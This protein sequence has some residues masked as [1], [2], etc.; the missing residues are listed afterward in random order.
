[1]RRRARPSPPECAVNAR[2]PSRRRRS[3]ALSVLLAGRGTPVTA[4]RRASAKLLAGRRR[5][6]SRERQDAE[7]L[8]HIIAR[9]RSRWLTDQRTAIKLWLRARRS[10]EYE[11]ADSETRRAMVRVVERRLQRAK[12]RQLRA[13]AT[14]GVTTPA[15]RPAVRG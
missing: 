13:D 15:Q 8:L 1:M 5:A 6:Q 12:A 2:L 7:K 3:G 10:G 4:K 14:V 11:R 9:F